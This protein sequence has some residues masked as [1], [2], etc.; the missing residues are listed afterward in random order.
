MTE[1]RNPLEDPQP[2]DKVF[3]ERWTPARERTVTKRNGYDIWYSD[4]KN[5][6][7]CFISTWQEWCRRNGAAIDG[8]GDDFSTP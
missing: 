7:M 2:G 3:S 5:E 4:G 6:R 1:P 8:G